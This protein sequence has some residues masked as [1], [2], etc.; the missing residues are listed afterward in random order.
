MRFDALKPAPSESLTRW[1]IGN[2]QFMRERLTIAD[3]L[4]LAGWLDEAG[5]GRI[6][7]RVDQVLA[8]VRGA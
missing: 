6:M 7:A 2:C 3:L 8:A 4:Y 5:V 1:V